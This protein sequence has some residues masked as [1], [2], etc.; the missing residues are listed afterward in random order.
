MP[1]SS[2]SFLNEANNCDWAWIINHHTASTHYDY[3]SRFTIVY[4]SPIKK[5]Q[6]VYA[7]NK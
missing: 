3:I 7:T 2:H 1:E 4:A 6:A 5:K